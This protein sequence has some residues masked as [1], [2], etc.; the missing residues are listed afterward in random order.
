MAF[1]VPWATT[2]RMTGNT[3][4]VEA[5][6]VRTRSE[7]ARFSAPRW[8]AV[9]INQQ[10]PQAAPVVFQVAAKGKDAVQLS[11]QPR[12]AIHGGED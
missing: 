1:E 8:S 12:G 3:P 4:A 11:V 6:G 7:D 9:E 5:N 10:R 2:L